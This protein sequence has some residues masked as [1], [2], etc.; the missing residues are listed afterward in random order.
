[1]VDF[2]SFAIKH[3]SLLAKE[4]EIS[5]QVVQNGSNHHLCWTWSGSAVLLKCP[6]GNMK[7]SSEF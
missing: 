6:Q 5:G 1:M 3:K 2:L 4:T 7:A